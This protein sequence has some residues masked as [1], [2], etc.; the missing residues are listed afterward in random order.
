MEGL[1]QAALHKAD[2]ELHQV[3]DMDQALD[4]VVRLKEAISKEAITNKVVRRKEGITNKVAHKGKTNR[5]SI[6][7]NKGTNRVGQTISKTTDKTIRMERMEKRK[8]PKARRSQFK[9]R[10]PAARWVRFSQ[11]VLLLLLLELAALR[12][13]SC[14][15]EKSLR[16]ILEVTRQV[17]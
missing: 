9:A 17:R 8:T 15:A 6:T 14:I 4:Q 10:D 7:T 11:E 13:T 3:E 2:T 5:A 1:L 16:E 12:S